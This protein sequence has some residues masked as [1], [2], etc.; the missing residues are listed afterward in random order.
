VQGLLPEARAYLVAQP[1]PG[2]VREFKNTLTRAMILAERPW[3]EVQDFRRATKNGEGPGSE[4]ESNV[5]AGFTLVEVVSR[6]VARVE[7]AHIEST[8]TLH[9][10]NR[11]ATAA[12][13]GINR[14]TLF[15]KM[16]SLGLQ[17]ANG[18]TD[19]PED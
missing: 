15:Y 2:N 18:E 16:R 13:L 3:L 5:T 8:L 14:K 19:T 6:T 17:D 1:W 12:A 9:R 7:R 4:S 11:T 10:G